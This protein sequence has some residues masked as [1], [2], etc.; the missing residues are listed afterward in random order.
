M[1][2]LFA[3]SAI[4]EG[5]RSED[6]TE[7]LVKALAMMGRFEEIREMWDEYARSGRRG[8]AA[9]EAAST[10]DR[11]FREALESRG[12]DETEGDRQPDK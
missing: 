1:S 4:Q 11:I 5:G 12:D 2:S 3:R 9:A 8:G 7:A 10:F 6:A